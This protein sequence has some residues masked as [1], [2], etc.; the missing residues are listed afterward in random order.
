[1]S[2]DIILCKCCGSIQVRDEDDLC[3]ECMIA[4]TEFY[5]LNEENMEE[6]TYE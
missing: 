4:K 3:P 5:G 2:T 1:M 6:C